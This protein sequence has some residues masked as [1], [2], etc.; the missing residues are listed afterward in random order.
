MKLYKNLT[1]AL[2]EREQVTAIKLSI[3]EKQ[4]P[5]ALFDLT[6]L[7][8]AYLDGECTEFPD[9]IH[10]WKN[11]KTLSI[12][13]DFFSGDLSGLFS[14]PSLENLKI[15]ETPMKHFL[16]PLGKI[17]APLKYLT[18]KSCKLEKLPEEIS[19]C[20]SLLEMH[21]PG[22]KLSTLPFSFKDLTHLRRLN[23]DHNLFHEFPD[24]I[25][26]MKNLGHLSIDG[27]E[28]SEEEKARI[29]REFHI[30]PN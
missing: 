3:K 23:L 13:W 1:T 2:K 21:L 7:T 18:I 19:M 20:A 14:L 15:I 27:N 25:K 9:H 16:L 17:N 30:W 11:L 5:T 10:G 29:Q 24:Q 8:E 26:L 12:K 4:F 6:N 22:N 28:F